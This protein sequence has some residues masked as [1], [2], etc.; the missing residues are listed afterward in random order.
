MYYILLKVPIAFL[1]HYCLM[2][3]SC[4][5]CQPLSKNSEFA[6]FCREGQKMQTF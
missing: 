5:P 1:S 3:V 4:L 6:T 2:I